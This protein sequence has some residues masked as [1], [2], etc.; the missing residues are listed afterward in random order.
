MSLGLVYTLLLTFPNPVQT[1]YLVE[2]FLPS[3]AA[4]NTPSS[5]KPSLRLFPP[6]QPST[7]RIILTTPAFLCFCS[8]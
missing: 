8:L 2:A 4:F 3:Q 1:S 5:R 7:H 6:S